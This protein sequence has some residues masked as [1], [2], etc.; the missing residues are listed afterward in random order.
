MSSAFRGGDKAARLLDA[1][2][3]PPVARS[4]SRRHARQYTGEAV[5]HEE[6]ASRSPRDVEH[7]RA[8]S[9]NAARA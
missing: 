8:L 1:R 4:G 2:R 9:E 3:L 6:T 7:F 5:T